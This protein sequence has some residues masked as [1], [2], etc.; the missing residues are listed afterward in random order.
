MIKGFE[1]PAGY[2]LLII[3]KCALR[4]KLNT[5]GDPLRRITQSILGEG[6]QHHGYL[7]FIQLSIKLEH[8]VYLM[9]NQ[10]ISSVQSTIIST[11]ITTTTAARKNNNRN[12]RRPAANFL[13]LL[14]TVSVCDRKLDWTRAAAAAVV[15]QP[16][17][18][19][20]CHKWHPLRGITPSILRES[21]NNIN[22]AKHQY[23]LV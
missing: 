21:V 16:S 5:E 22:T 23:R 3:C 7:K 11:T 9:Q 8:E 14:F 19:Q 12:R 13:C 18:R 2:L 1:F 20:P 10:G 4:F 6:E 17:F 15:E